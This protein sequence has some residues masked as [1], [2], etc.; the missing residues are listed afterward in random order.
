L[1]KA[2][3]QH[4]RVVMVRR[5]WPTTKPAH[6]LAKAITQLQ[7]DDMPEDCVAVFFLAAPDDHTSAAYQA[8]YQTA[9]QHALGWCESA[10]QPPKRFILASSTAVYH[11]QDGAW[12][13]EC[14][15]T[16]PERFNGQALLDAEQCCAQSTI[17]TVVCRFGGIYGR[18]KSRWIQQLKSGTAELAKQ[19]YWIN[20]IHHSDVVGIL[21]HLMRREVVPPVVVPPVVVCVDDQPV[22]QH[23]LYRWCAQ[24]CGLPC[25]SIAHQEITRRHGGNRRCSNALLHQFSYDLQYPSYQQGLQHAIAQARSGDTKTNGE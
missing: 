15:A 7:P 25:P 5:Q 12:V 16:K 19:D 23:Q 11:Q 24:Q 13:D 17:E 21:F 10:K 3:D 6:A 22:R 14:S 20:L 8:V 1:A 18:G 2:L 9:L 4:Y